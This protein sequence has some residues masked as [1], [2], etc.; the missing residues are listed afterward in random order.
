MAKKFAPPT[1]EELQAFQVKEPASNQQLQ[2][3]EPAKPKE[4]MSGF[5]PPSP[6]ELQS[7]GI[8]PS[9]RVS[10]E[11][12]TPLSGV[13]IG[14]S[15]LPFIGKTASTIMGGMRTVGELGAKA[16]IK[17]GLVS[18]G[19]ETPPISLAE[20]IRKAEEERKG[21]VRGAEAQV[22]RSVMA[23]E[24]GAGLG[25][26]VGAGKGLK[27]L[28]AAP[29]VVTRIGS[30]ILTGAATA[31][32][33]NPEE[34]I[35]NRM[36]SVLFAPE[37]P[38]EGAVGGA[39]L[40]LAGEVVGFGAKQAAKAGRKVFEGIRRVSPDVVDEYLKNPSAVN[41]IIKEKVEEYIPRWADQA[42]DAIKS[43]V[44]KINGQ[45]D[46][47]L[48]KFGSDKIVS[49]K[50]LKKQAMDALDDISKLKVTSE[51]L[52]DISQLK[53]QVKLLNQLDDN[54]SV[55]QANEI[56]KRLQE[57]AGKIN[58]NNNF[59]TT[60][61]EKTISNLSKQSRI[62]VEE[63]V[64][65]VV[66]L[67]QSLAKSIKAQKVLKIKNVFKEGVIDEKRARL[68]LGK[69]TR[70]EINALRDLDD[71]FGTDLLKS[72]Q[73][74]QA[75]KELGNESLLQSIP[76]GRASLPFV[77]GGLADNFLGL[78]G[79]VTGGLGVLQ[80]P[81]ASRPIIDIA[82]G[83]SRVAPTIRNVGLAGAIS[84]RQQIADNLVPKNIKN[85]R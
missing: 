65:E 68:I 6:E 38:I 16:A 75:A 82:R 7:F 9:Q 5:A 52:K 11:K 33:R 24:I 12:E 36:L 44:I 58:S 46:D 2:P 4:S 17:T 84:G 55:R 13:I 69:N 39:G 27:A 54:V 60:Q 77:I 14:A 1:A 51:D 22:P 73:I 8:D 64:P 3:T 70:E 79:A 29:G 34:R 56:K 63:A 37:T 18:G 61:L 47:V 85:K 62:L 31:R 59:R 23:G 41:K 53:N 20:N 76:T 50:P 26:F 42:A 81:I 32:E 83:V 28:G 15:K 21:V 25:T 40:G 80:S 74:Y 48:N 57:F 66:D 43:G 72:K 19:P 45:I 35:A 49:L 71:V 67:N 78:P 10:L 30:S